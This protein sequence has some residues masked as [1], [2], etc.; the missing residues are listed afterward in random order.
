MKLEIKVFRAGSIGDVD[1]LVAKIRSLAEEV[2]ITEV[3]FDPAWETTVVQLLTAEGFPAEKIVEE[4]QT[5][6]LLLKRQD[7]KP[8]WPKVGKL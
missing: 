7:K 6:S 4:K 2:E 1:K 3:R 5:R 8:T